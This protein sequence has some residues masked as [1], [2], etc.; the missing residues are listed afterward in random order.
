MASLPGHATQKESILQQPS[1]NDPPAYTTN[2]FRTAV[3]WFLSC[4][5]KFNNIILNHSHIKV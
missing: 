5:S 2:I 1:T 3:M 4:F